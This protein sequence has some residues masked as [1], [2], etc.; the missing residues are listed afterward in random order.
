MKHLLLFAF[1][2]SFI[3][4]SFGQNLQLHYDFTDAN[5]PKADNRD[6]ITATFEM[7]RPDSMGS[8]FW[9][10]DLD[11]NGPNHEPNLSYLEIARD[12]KT[13]SFPLAFHGEYNG[14]FLY[15]ERRGFG[16]HFSNVLIFG[17]S[18]TFKLG[19]VSIGTYVGYKFIDY[20]REGADFQLTSTWFTMF[21][22]D[23]IT[24]TGFIDF[25]TEDDF[26][27]ENKP[28]GKKLIILTEPQIWYNITKAFAIGGEIELSH[29]FI[30]NSKKFEVFPTVGLKVDF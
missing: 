22:N 11:F 3:S 13:W 10:I 16:N 12:F 6:Y 29:N 21:W 8:T 30:Y 9:F 26:N 1:I 17:P 7:F 19:K 20:S 27:A 15:N 18:T 23:K 25:W 28:D 5:S 4:I 14:G 24:F 2:L